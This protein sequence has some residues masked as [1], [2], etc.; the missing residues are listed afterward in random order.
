MREGEG[1]G[2]KYHHFSP[3]APLKSAAPTPL[4]SRLTAP[5]PHCPRQTRAMRVGLLRAEADAQFADPRVSELRR[6]HA[7]LLANRAYAE[8]FDSMKVPSFLS[9]TWCL[10]KLGDVCARKGPPPPAYKK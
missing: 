1:G 5:T 7:Q 2:R 4:G 3:A 6:R 10:T 8:A 9:L